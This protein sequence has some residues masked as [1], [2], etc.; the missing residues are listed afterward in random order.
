M[1]WI[2]KGLNYAIKPIRSM[3]GT[4]IVGVRWGNVAIFLAVILF[5]AIGA[6][7]TANKV[8]EVVEVKY[9][10]FIEAGKVEA[11]KQWSSQF[12]IIEAIA[13]EPSNLYD[14][15]SQYLDGEELN[16]QMTVVIEE[17]PHI[18]KQFVPSGAVV[19]LVVKK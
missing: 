14:L 3:K 13:H 12:S 6:G 19:Q 10:E 7:V 17:N 8:A 5:S 1:E 4:R 18:Q 11:K 16:R 9:D 2:L 15:Q